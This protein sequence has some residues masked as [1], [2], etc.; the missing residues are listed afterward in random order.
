MYCKHCGNQIDSDSKFCS[1][2]GREV[3]LQGRPTASQ[4]EIP[5]SAIQ[6]TITKNVYQNK[7]DSTY[8][9]DSPTTAVGIVL[10]IL[11]LVLFYLT[12]GS[13]SGNNDIAVMSIISLVV[14]IGITVWVVDIAK[15]LNRNSTGW[16]IFAF[17]L[18]FISLIVIGQM[19]KLAV[20]A[21]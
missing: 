6:N 7:Y 20:P 1:F 2:C 12:D 8:E 3:N 14:R 16:G 10:I 18:P 21:P 9:K 19:R 11:S 15:K 17:F 5:K 4:L 13:I